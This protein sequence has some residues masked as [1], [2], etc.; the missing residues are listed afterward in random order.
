M[1]GSVVEAQSRG[2]SAGQTAGG[3]IM[4]ETESPE[5]KQEPQG[6]GV[7]LVVEDNRDD[8]LLLRMA[9]WH[10]G[11]TNKVEY[12]WDG[13]EAE[14]YLRGDG[15][16]GNRTAH[17]MPCLIITDLKMS[18]VTGL[19]LLSWLQE[20]EG[21]KGLPVIVMSCSLAESDRKEAVRLGAREYIVK[22]GRFEELREVVR[23]I[24]RRWLGKQS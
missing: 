14:S 10:E 16:Y 11:V 7:V 19:A 15:D 1:T 8:A 22:P 24:K 21:L 6:A 5:A 23:D 18:P 12:V 17:P 13:L 20:Q 9:F 4:R 2:R 3:K